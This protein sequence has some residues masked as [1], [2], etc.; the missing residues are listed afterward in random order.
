MLPLANRRTVKTYCSNCHFNSRSNPRVSPGESNCAWGNDQRH[1]TCCFSFSPVISCTNGGSSFAFRVI[2]FSSKSGTEM[3]RTSSFS[4][5]SF[6]NDWKINEWLSCSCRWTNSSTCWPSST[7]RFSD[8]SVSW[9]TRWRRFRSF[10][11]LIRRGRGHRANLS[12]C[13]AK[14]NTRRTA[15]T[16]LSLSSMTTIAGS[17]VIIR[18]ILRVRFQILIMISIFNTHSTTN[19]QLK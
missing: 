12:H 17:R 11:E 6:A 15:S 1:A 2:W 16:R 14:K 13:S 4:N 19:G 10:S 7:S 18:L 9:T 3:R 8:S 5:E